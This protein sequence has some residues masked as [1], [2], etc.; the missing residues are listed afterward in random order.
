LECEVDGNPLKLGMIRWFRGQEEVKPFV[1][2]QHRS[3]LRI[4][5]THENSGAYTCLVDNGIGKVFLFN[6]FLV[7]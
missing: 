6:D 1:L 2:E 5:A 7:K 4:I 3:V